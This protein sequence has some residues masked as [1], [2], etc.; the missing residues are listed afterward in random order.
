MKR[1]IST[2]A[3][4]LF[5]S[6]LPAAFFTSCDKDTN[7]YVD[8]LVLN[9]Q[10]RT[11][12]SGVTVE[13]FQNN[14]DPSDY[15]YAIGVTDAKGIFSTHYDSPGILE[16][17]ATLSTGDGGYRR[18]KGNVRLVEG[19]TKTAEVTLGAVEY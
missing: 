18:G 9:E 14:C 19:E 7:S 17:K 13:L 16:I 6:L 3:A 15:K 4:L 10:G 12:V 5:I 8:V 2:L 11:P 1:K